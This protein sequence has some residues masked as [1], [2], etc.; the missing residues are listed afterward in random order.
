VRFSFSPLAAVAALLQLQSL[1]SKNLIP[2]FC[3]NSPNTPAVHSQ[4]HDAAVA[5][6]TMG[7]MLVWLS[8]AEIFGTA[9]TIQML[10]VSLSLT[11]KVF[12]SLSLSLS[13]SIYIYIYI[14]IYIHIYIYTYT[15]IYV[16]ICIYIYIYIA[17]RIYIYIYIYIYISQPDCIAP[18]LCMTDREKGSGGR[19]Y[20][21]TYTEKGVGVRKY[22]YGPVF[23]LPIHPKGVITTAAVARAAAVDS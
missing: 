21:I 11:H 20:I 15:Y 6:G 18:G 10:Q 23:L 22:L 17:A 7:Q 1:T 4:L 13:L 2:I 14:H 3:F 9:A 8:F 19:K 12:C 5:E 16:Y